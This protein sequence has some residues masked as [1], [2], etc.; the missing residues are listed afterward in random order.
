M[1]SASRFR[2]ARAYSSLT[3]SKGN[4]LPLDRIVL[5]GLQFFGFHGVLERVGFTPPPPRRSPLLKQTPTSGGRRRSIA[6]TLRTQHLAAAGE[7]GG[8]G[9]HRG[10]RLTHR[11]PG[12]CSSR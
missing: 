2:Y 12:S 6:N 7:G 10:R 9:F 4:P 8:T 11:V 3:T 5:R 1:L